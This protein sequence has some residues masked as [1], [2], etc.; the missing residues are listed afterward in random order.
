MHAQRLLFGGFVLDPAHGTLLRDEAPV[1]IGH[2]AKALLAA[3]AQADGRVLTKAELIDA[4]WPGA[5]VEES[6]LSVQVAALRK[7]LGST[8]DD[9]EAIANVAR[10][11]YRFCLPVEI[12]PSTGGDDPHHAAV[13]DARP[14]LSALT[15]YRAS[16]VCIRRR[17]GGTDWLLSGAEVF[18]LRR[19]FP[20]PVLTW[21]RGMR[22]AEY[23]FPRGG[24]ALVARKLAM[25]SVREPIRR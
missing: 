11:G 20:S 3:L 1:A 23:P 12:A 4:A 18:R 15:A 10:V 19:C 25:L 21:T 6:N 2:R 17:R 8:L 9:G 16:G 22:K 5:V 7:L 24:L 14:S 13:A